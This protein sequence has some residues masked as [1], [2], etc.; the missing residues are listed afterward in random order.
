VDAPHLFHFRVSHYNEKARWALDFKRWPH[1]RTALVPGFHIPRARWMTGQNQLP[2]IRLE[3]RTIAGSNHI[4]AELERLRPDPPLYPRD[5]RERA[6]AIAIEKHF[7]EEVAPDLRRIFWSTY[8]SR[9]AVCSRMST[10][11]FGTSTRVLWRAAFLILRPAFVRNMGASRSEVDRARERMA[12]HFDR[13]ESEIG[14]S[15]FLVGDS[16]TIADLTAAAV[17]TAIIRPPQFPYPLP[18]PWPEELVE[19]RESVS[20]RDG[21]RWVLGIYERHR[22]QSCEITE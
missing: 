5:E 22:P 15:G 17:M 16:F 1:H 14:S 21:F 8:L 2:I 4:L 3:G 12:G 20:H 11:G 18:D 7:D 6:R 9:P 13:L 10:D 19:I